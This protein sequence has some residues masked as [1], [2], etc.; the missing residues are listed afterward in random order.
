MATPPQFLQDKTFR[1]SL[2]MTTAIGGGF[3]SLNK[4]GLLFGASIT[5]T[6]ENLNV[7]TSLDF[8]SELNKLGCKVILFVEYV[9]VE[10]DNL[11][12]NNAQREKLTRK[13][14]LIREH[15]N[16]LIIISFPGDEAESGGCLVAGCGFFHINA[17]GGA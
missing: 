4:N 8:V 16:S 6:S 12:L 13:I 10:N 5:V 15:Q 17:R 2:D 7:V 11:A 14:E 9:P 1:H 3:L